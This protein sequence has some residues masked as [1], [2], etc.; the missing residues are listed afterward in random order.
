MIIRPKKWEEYQHYKHRNPPW[1]RL[2]KRLLDDCDFQC[3]HDASK[4]LAMCLWLI[5]SEYKNG[6]INQTIKQLC[7]RL[8]VEETK[9]LTALSELESQG[10]MVVTYTE[11]DKCLHDASTMLAR[12]YQD[13]TT[14]TDNT[15]TDNTE[16]KTK[17]EK[18]KK[19]P[20]PKV[21]LIEL[22]EFV[23][24]DAWF[25]FLEMRKKIKKPATERACA[26]LIKKLT[27]YHNAGHDPNAIL[28]QSTMN[29]WQD[30]Y[31]LKADY[32]QKRSGSKTFDQIRRE[33]TR[34]A[35]IEFAGG[36]DDRGGQESV[37]G[38]DDRDG[39]GVLQGR[40]Q[41]HNGDLFP[42]SV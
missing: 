16:L 27:M 8:R 1:I 33:N 35:A 3:L 2:H 9:F 6:E 24:P 36:C 28:D 13:A 14:E 12:C 42:I 40:E 4:V 22:P 18:S 5:A 26:M 7:F 21:A 23:S 41:R 10:F 39:G 20:Q 25:G 30:L 34:K 29:S 32:Q 17:G 31:E 11:H 38:F 37:C 15:E 19:S